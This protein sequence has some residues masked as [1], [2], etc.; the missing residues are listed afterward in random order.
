MANKGLSKS[1]YTKFRQCDKALWLRVYHP[2]LA[3]EDPQTAAR[4]QAG[5]EVGDLAMHLFGDYVEV[6]TLK[7]DG[8][9]DLKA[10]LDKTQQ[11]LSDGTQ[12]IC[13]AS[14]TFEGCYCA[15]DILRN[16][17][18]GTWDIIEVK[19][20]TEPHEYH[21][22]DVSFEN[23]TNLVGQIVKVQYKK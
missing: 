13:E 11:C 20:A 23:P 4:F 16:N 8:T 12:N 7:A 10:M 19:S 17:N 5:N 15:V 9:L 2:E 21:Y 6:T 3:V 22:L 14:F 18:D 1:K